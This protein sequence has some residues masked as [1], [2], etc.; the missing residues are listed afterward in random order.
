MEQPKQSNNAYGL[1][2]LIINLNLKFNF[3]GFAAGPY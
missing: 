3:K 2:K 1:G